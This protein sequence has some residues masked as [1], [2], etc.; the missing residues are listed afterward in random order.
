M[1]ASTPRATI[2]P[3][4]DGIPLPVGEG[5]LRVDAIAVIPAL[6]RDLGVD[7]DAFLANAGLDPKLFD[8]P[9]NEIPIATLGRLLSLAAARSGC[10]HFG[11]LVGQRSGLASLGLI[12]LLVRHSPDVGTALRNL[13]GHLH[14]RD[15][16]AVAPL[17]L[18]GGMATLGYEIYHPGVEGSEQIQDGALA[19]GMNV[20]K[21]LCGRTWRPSEVLFCHGKP[22][23]LRPFRRI[24]AAPL[25]FDA[26]RSALVFPAAWLER[27]TSGADAAVYR[28][29]ERRVQALE[30]SAAGDLVAELRRL[31]RTLLPGAR[32]SVEE[33]A[34]R[35][36]IH[37]RTLNRRLAARGTSLRR[38]VEETRFEIARQLV[39]NTS[40]PLVEVSAALGYA[41][42]SAFTRAFRRWS[43]A[44]PS[45]WRQDRRES[46]DANCRAPRA[47]VAY[48]RRARDPRA[49]L[50]RSS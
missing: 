37:R 21:A 10:P 19:I 49:S 6:L 20:V 32:G 38:L 25:H 35:L 12:E 43:G 48:A 29:A 31:L 2:G 1:A 11:L 4:D 5:I 24:F 50:G 23:D 41:D 47:A 30:A 34:E 13:A 16:G 3:A 18:K 26:E 46:R 28:R 8:D 40:M 42:A 45:G 27:R 39:E 9:L 44:A 7:P 17:R 14:V 22:E 33:V 36:A 15:R